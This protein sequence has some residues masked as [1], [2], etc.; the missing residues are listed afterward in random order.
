M[1]DRIEARISRHDSEAAM[2]NAGEFPVGIP[3]HGV[4]ELKEEAKGAV[5]TT[6]DAF[7]NVGPLQSVTSPFDARPVDAEIFPEPAVSA[8]AM[9]DY[10][11]AARAYLESL[12][13]SDPNESVAAFQKLLGS[14]AVLSDVDK[15]TGRL[16]DAEAA[17]DKLTAKKERAIA[18]WEKVSRASSFMGAKAE[19]GFAAVLPGVDRPGTIDE[20]EKQIEAAGAA[21]AE[22]RLS[23][24]SSIVLFE[25][26]VKDVVA[27][28][29]PGGHEEEVALA[30]FAMSMVA[31]VLVAVREIDRA[32]EYY[33]AASL[34]A[35]TVA[36]SAWYRMEALQLEAM[37][38]GK[39]AAEALPKIKLIRDGLAQLAWQ[40]TIFKDGGGVAKGTIG[41]I[42]EVDGMPNPGRPED[43]QALDAFSW[44]VHYEALQVSL[45]EPEAR[46][47]AVEA[48]IEALKDLEEERRTALAARKNEADS[49]EA[50]F[51]LTN[52]HMVASSWTYKGGD[53]ERALRDEGAEEAATLHGQL[54]K[55]LVDAKE[56]GARFAPGASDEGFKD[57]LAAIEWRVR[58]DGFFS[59][60]LPQDA[61]RAATNVVVPGNPGSASV[62]TQIDGLREIARRAGVEGV[63]FRAD[64]SINAD[65]DVSALPAGVLAGSRAESAYWTSP[66]LLREMGLPFA[67]ASLCYGVT[68]LALTTGP[69]AFIAGGACALAATAGNQQYNTRVLGA[70]ASRQASATGLSRVDDNEAEKFRGAWF[71]NA[72]INSIFSSGFANMG[73]STGRF[74]VG[75]SLKLGRGIGQVFSSAATSIAESK[76]LGA[77]LLNGS[78]ATGRLV[79]QIGGGAWNKM[80]AGDMIHAGASL[81]W[82]AD[83]FFIDADGHFA[84]GDGKVDH[85]IGYAGKTVFWGGLAYRGFSLTWNDLSK[86][87]VTRGGKKVLLEGFGKKVAQQQWRGWISRAGVDIA[88]ADYYLV[89]EK[90]ITDEKGDQKKSETEFELVNFGKSQASEMEQ[91]A[92]DSQFGID[93]WMGYGGLL[94]AGGDWVATEFRTLP[95]HIDSASRIGWARGRALTGASLVGFDL[96]D[97]SQLNTWWMGGLGGALLMNEAGSILLQ[98][99]AMGSLVATGFRAGTEWLLQWQQDVPIKMPDAKR[100]MFASAES[101]LMRFPAKAYMM[102]N[103][104]MKSY[105]LGRRLVA[106]H[107][108]ALHSKYALISGAASFVRPIEAIGGR[109]VIDGWQNAIVRA[110]K[111]KVIRLT[112]DDCGAPLY[113]SKGKLLPGKEEIHLRVISQ[114]AHLTRNWWSESRQGMTKIQV[115]D[116][117]YELT[118]KFKNPY[119][120]GLLKYNGYH[121]T[122]GN[123]WKTEVW[124]KGQKR[125]GGKSMSA[126]RYEAL[127]AKDQGDFSQDLKDQGVTY[128]SFSDMTTEQAASV[129]ADLVAMGAYKSGMKGAFMKRWYVDP[130]TPTILSSHGKYTDETQSN[131]TFKIDGIPLRNGF[132]E[133]MRGPGNDVWF[134]VDR[135]MRAVADVQVG[136][137]VVEYFRGP[138][139][140]PR[141][142]ARGIMIQGLL[143][144]GTS[145]VATDTIFRHAMDGDPKYQAWQR[146]FNYGVSE[147][148][149]HPFVQWPLGY[150]T[151]LAQFAGRSIGIFVNMVGN[152]FFS[153]YLNSWPGLPMYQRSLDANPNGTLTDF[154]MGTPV[155]YPT[156]RYWR[157][158]LGFDAM[159]NEPMEGL[160]TWQNTMKTSQLLPIGFWGTKS[161]PTLAHFELRAID[162]FRLAEECQREIA[163]DASLAAALDKTTA[164][165]KD[166]KG[167]FDEKDLN[168]ALEKDTEKAMLKQESCQRLLPKTIE[169]FV[170]QS[171]EDWR[172]EKDRVKTL[173]DRATALAKNFELW[174]ERERKGRLS[175]TER[176][177]LILMAAHMKITLKKVRETEPELLPVYKEWAE[178]QAKYYEA[179][180]GNIEIEGDEKKHWEDFI[181]D[182]NNGDSKACDFH[183]KIKL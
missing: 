15:E 122:D 73:A 39:A 165:F 8:E 4:C 175:L 116:K 162:T 174:M 153:T 88:L 55:D 70:E 38:G 27:A 62:A 113:D 109:P 6:T 167:G 180:F 139:G 78:K 143:M 159:K 32:Q 5:E 107:T 12:D 25:A 115:G 181:R 22:A 178:L 29:V 2:G 141:L 17:L 21:V 176:R 47:G 140:R 134:K 126:R 96:Y 95:L 76:S 91:R 127:N 51:H 57:K 56:M 34:S 128:V 19:F 110:D 170:K 36:Q 3:E 18:E 58:V 144:S 157:E 80:S 97:D 177:T 149:T 151:P 49:F 154:F 71:M 179:L 147:F 102:G 66:S 120:K 158:S 161:G 105:P 68:A 24:Y 121:V 72:G 108:S 106:L 171:L 119:I 87:V 82:P 145:W 54:E 63:L 98:V 183:Y 65:A 148:A 60:D 33:N 53:I 46:T 45:S 146:V 112:R 164:E 48:R 81:G 152:E 138:F 30:P 77:L 83:Y 86:E 169:S 111:H 43:V 26:L 1:T 163:T 74:L 42:S 101:A 137:K 41:G 100:L 155:L 124:W 50:Q 173:G 40:A 172:K 133:W 93:T 130:E 35:E 85:W 14:V 11:R 23:K 90:T 16:L 114:K 10:D 64:G 79:R 9:A 135:E 61:I 13:A 132:G 69:G 123:L 89:N 20:L 168:K 142:S 37:K 75:G 136:G 84:P 150:D 31:R 7:F 131:C 59:R 118:S 156:Y 104:Y 99:D 125:V 103:H 166:K 117:V 28:S 94:L 160:E 129:K 67:A 92:F 44:G 52:M 182:V